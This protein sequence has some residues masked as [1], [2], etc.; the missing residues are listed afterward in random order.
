MFAVANYGHFWRR[1]RVDF[2]SRGKK[3]S[4]LGYFGP[5]K[6]RRKVDFRDQIGI[7]VLYDEWREVVYIGQAG[8]GTQRLL[9]RLRA[10]TRDHLRDRW[11]YFSWL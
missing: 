10:H 2:G 9:S 8:S 4:L 5:Q 1:E 7:Y 3:S 6:D 11:A